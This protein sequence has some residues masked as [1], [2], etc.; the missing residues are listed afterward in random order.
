MT[1]RTLIIAVIL[2]IPAFVFNVSC[3]KEKPIAEESTIEPSFEDPA[4]EAP[5]DWGPQG[6]EADTEEDEDMG[7][8]YEEDEGENEDPG[9][10]SE[11]EGEDKKSEPE[12]DEGEN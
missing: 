5:F 3:E 1:V 12:E 7:Y 4:E 11:E 9:F 10:K 8:E 2:I 6:D